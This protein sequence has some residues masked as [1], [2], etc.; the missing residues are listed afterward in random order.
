MKGDKE[1]QENIVQNIISIAHQG[2]KDK[3]YF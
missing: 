2:T 1:A 3:K